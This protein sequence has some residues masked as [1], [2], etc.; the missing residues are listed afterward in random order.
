ESYPSEDLAKAIDNQRVLI[1]KARRTWK[2]MPD[3]PLTAAAL[4]ANCNVNYGVNLDAYPL[5]GSQGVGAVSDAYFNDD[6]GI[7]GDTNAYAYARATLN[8]TTTTVTKQDP[9][10]GN[11]VTSHA[12]A[13]AYGNLDCYSYAFGSASSAGLAINYSTSDTNTD[14]PPPPPTVTISGPTSVG[15]IG[16][17][18]RIITWTSSVSG[19]TPGYSYSWT[20]DGAPAGTGTST[21][22][23]YCGENIAW[24]Q[25]VN[26]ALTVTD[27]ANQQGSD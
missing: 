10:S 14:C 3:T 21:S 5:S 2:Q 24:T 16:W 6:C 26:I 15:I 23:E 12:A 1:A 13:T 11:P 4:P 25:T 27:A 17:D 22:Q 7:S 18:C 19:G 9:H 20:I 8:G